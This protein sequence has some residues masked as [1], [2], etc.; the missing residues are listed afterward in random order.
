LYYFIGISLIFSGCTIPFTDKVI[1]LPFIE[2][3]PDEVIPLM[4]DKMLNSQAHGFITEADLNIRIEPDK[5]TS[6]RQSEINR[7]AKYFMPNTPMVLGADTESSK[8]L[9]IPAFILGRPLL[10]REPV[11]LLFK[12][13]SNGYYEA[14][15]KDN[16]KTKNY[17]QIK[18]AV[19]GTA[20]DFDLEAISA[21]E[22]KYYKVAKSPSLLFRGFWRVG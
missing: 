6:E 15:D 19:D 5:L 21:G 3:K 4:L 2:K 1:F 20:L 17:H 16:I 8:F 22:K 18:M 7:I 11:D 12:I 14:K 9:T 13:S 10:G